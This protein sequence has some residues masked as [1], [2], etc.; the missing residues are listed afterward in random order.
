MDIGIA[1]PSVGPVGE[2]EMVLDVAR[3]AERNGFHSVWTQDH[4]A[5][6]R[7]R[8][9][10]YPYPE[11]T[12]EL[13]FSPGIDWLDPV[14]VMG[15]VAGATERLVIGTSVLVLPYRHPVV[16]AQELASLDRLSE[17]RIVLGI[18]SGWMD[19]EFAAV[20]V[21]KRERG[22]RTDEAM[23]LMRA[24][25]ATDD[26]LSF[27]GRFWRLDE[28]VLASHPSRPGGPPIMVGG[29][30]EPALRRAG[31]LGDGWLGF[32]VFLDGVG[33]C[34]DAISRAA[35]EA[36]RDPAAITLSVRRGLVPPFEV[37]NFLP[38]RRSIAGSPEDVAA[39]IRAYGDAGVTLLVLDLPFVL[40]DVLDTMDWLAE[41]AVPL[42]DAD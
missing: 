41:E 2:R 29:N 24:L 16:L 28:V 1:L 14:A 7:T 35:Q 34:R 21:P 5:F 31:R 18:G 15:V 6:P 30:T 36:G 39:E 17:G 27:D 10:V 25:W 23:D 9:S 40:P 4:I 38:E 26:P 12:T 19:E 3:R 11:T 13:A 37:S 22:A 8:T 33:A 20:G 32:E 42:L